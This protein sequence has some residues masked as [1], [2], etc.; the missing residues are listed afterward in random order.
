[1]LIVINDSCILI[2][3]QKLDIFEA[4]FQLP[5]DFRI[6]DALYY[7]E[8]LSLTIEQTNAIK[9]RFKI[10]S[11]TG[12]QVSQALVYKSQN[13]RLSTY[14]CFALTLAQSYE[15]SILLTS[16]NA[17]RQT[18]ENNNIRKHGLLWVL[19]ELFNHNIVSSESILRLLQTIKNDDMFHQ[20]KHE[21]DKRIKRH[22][23][24]KK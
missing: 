2:D 20:P 11:L 5:Y 23:Q 19:D 24:D 17:L 8:L 21:V 3:I 1:M 10:E 15:N 9:Q 4:F 6:A 18:A 16:D 13:N 22:S 7:N 12:Q 14:D